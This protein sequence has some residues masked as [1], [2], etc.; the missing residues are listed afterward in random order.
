MNSP[1]QD[2][3]IYT[4][5][6]LKSELKR[7]GVNIGEAGAWRT[8]GTVDVLPADIGKRILFENNGIFYIDDEGIKRRGFMYKTS[9]YF[10]YQGQSNKPKFHVCKCT[11]IENFGKNAYR[12]ANAEPVKVISRNNNKEVM[13][14]HMELCGFCRKILIQIQAEANKIKDSTDFV[15]I[16]KAAGEVKEPEQLELDYKGYIKGWESISYTFRAKHNFT[17]QRCGI[18]VDDGFDHQYIQTHH[19]N[20]KKTDNSE[21]NLECLCVQCHSE[22]DAVHRKNFSRGGNKVI[23]QN[24]IAKY[25]N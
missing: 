23:L 20:G 10:K 13:V 12:F 5:P 9:F 19:R 22:V 24:F 16:L 6:Q 21:K 8:V 1:E 18:K 14:D 4:F 11:A 17:C 7:M 3:P 25:R 15:E 2:M